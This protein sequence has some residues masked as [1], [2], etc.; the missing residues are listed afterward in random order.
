[1][2]RVMK[3]LPSG[4]GA[5]AAIG[6]V[7]VAAAAALGW[8][9]AGR[10]LAAV[11]PSGSTAASGQSAAMVLPL[12]PSV[13]AGIRPSPR[14]PAPARSAIPPPGG[15][16]VDVLQEMWE[17]SLL[18]PRK[19]ADTP[20]TAENWFITGVFTR[21]DEQQ[22]IVQ[23]GND[24]KPHFHKVGDTLPGGAQINW[25]RPNVIGLTTPGKESIALPLTQP[26]RAA[27]SAAP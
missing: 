11:E 13:T 24:P 10:G 12:P 8:F 23:R 6:A 3:H 22:V 18:M 5:F 20:L 16:P 21:G 14:A 19:V 25:V 26:V 1:M 17:A 7:I 27:A 2:K 9:T 4:I 15:Y